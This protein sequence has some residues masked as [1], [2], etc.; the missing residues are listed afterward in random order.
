LRYFGIFD[1]DFRQVLV[2]SMESL[3]A[4]AAAQMAGEPTAEGKAA[5]I[6]V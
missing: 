5:T 6:I 2:G 1:G 4:T 3:L